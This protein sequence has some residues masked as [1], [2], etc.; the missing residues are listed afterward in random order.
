MKISEI[1]DLKVEQIQLD[2]V[3]IDLDI[4]YPIFIDPFLISQSASTWAVEVDA[5]IKNFFNNVVENIL[6]GNYRRA[7]ELFMFMAEPKETC[8]G[9]S[10]SGTNKGKGVGE[11]NAEKIIGEIIKSKA[12]EDGLVRNIEDIIVFVEDIDKDKLSDMV[13]NI[14]RKHL[15]EYTKIQCELWGISTQIF[16]S[17][18]YWNMEI[19]DWDSS[20]EEHL[21]IDNR[22]IILVPKSIV[23]YIKEYSAQKYNWHFVVDREVGVHLARRSSLVKY[24]KYKNGREKYYVTKTDVD[25]F[26]G[27]QI[28]EGEYDSRKE[29]LR[30]YTKNNPELFRDFKAYTGNRAKTLDDNEL[31]KHTGEIDVDILVDSLISRLKNIPPGK[32]FANKYH[33]FIKSV[34]E[35]IFYPNLN[36]PSMEERIHDGRKRIDI[37]M[38][39]NSNT[40]FFHRLHVKN[41]IF[42]PYIY[43]E[44]KNY[45]KDVS[46]PE[47]DQLSGRFSTFRGRFGIL[48]CRSLQ[49]EELFLK[50]CV[51][52]YKDNR[53]LVIPLIDDDIIKLLESYK[54]D[55]KYYV[56]NYLEKIRRKIVMS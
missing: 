23:S 40:G 13:T 43:I 14:I 56:D 20:N 5:T 35:I 4:D 6:S 46:N 21:V 15:L 18:P 31:M 26:I 29:F 28:K 24:R 3:D 9:V 51:D 7:K 54:N 42:C 41:N 25:A 47:I 10:S 55:D 36:N 34:L 30:I 50:R 45:G 49:N 53:G 8:L 27:R 52:T 19:E 37:V 11:K 2:F 39:N 16:E 48:M 1:F 17:L 33:I 12:I 38:H 32:D 44:C 22:E